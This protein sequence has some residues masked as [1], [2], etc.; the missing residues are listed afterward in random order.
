[1][2]LCKVLPSYSIYGG[3]VYCSLPYNAVEYVLNSDIA[4]QMLEA[5]KSSAIGEE[6][7]FQTVLMNSPLKSS[8]ISSN[9]RYSD[10]SV[11]NAPKILNEEDYKSIV[12]SNALFCR[13]V[14]LNISRK[15]FELLPL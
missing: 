6:I 8:I 4:K 5:L 9:L 12:V 13:K 2:G 3:S 11:V 15:L 14:D 10:W 7:F 1:M